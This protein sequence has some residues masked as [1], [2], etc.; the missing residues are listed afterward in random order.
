MASTMHENFGVFRRGADALAGRDHPGLTERYE[1]VVVEDSGSVFNTDLTQAL[2]PGPA[3]LAVVGGGIAC[4][5]SR[6]AHAR[7][8]TIP[9]ATT[10]TS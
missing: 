5:E 10:R 3:Q 2:E 4:K 8:P 6:G 1:R 7:P 9:T